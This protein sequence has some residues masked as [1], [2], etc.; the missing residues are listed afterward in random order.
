VSAEVRAAI[1]LL[2]R[3]RVDVPRQGA[4]GAA[5][6]GAVGGLIGLAGLVPLLLLGS[7]LPF[8]AALLALAVVAIA[9]GGLH[10]DG[11]A[12]TADALVAPDPEAAERARA[13]PAIGT[14]GAAAL[15]LV[16]GLEAV[17][18]GALAAGPG[19]VAAG[20]ACLV[21]A[22]LS[23][24]SAVALGWLAGA[25]ADGRLGGWFAATTNGIASAIALGTAALAAAAAAFV[26]RSVALPLAGLLGLGVGLA[27]GGWIVR[28]RGRLDGDALGATIEL[29]FASILLAAAVL[30]R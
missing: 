10:L 22:V 21:A 25:S 12:D 19:P 29:T 15:F 9:S 14:G 1:A 18:L 30:V 28:V 26:G 13:D 16:L 3:L 4:T 27:V 17:S 23:R 8:G 20:L 7:T 6:F 5:A 11:L 24:A 2:T